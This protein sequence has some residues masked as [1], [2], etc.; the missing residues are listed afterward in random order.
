MELC[1]FLTY[2]VNGCVQVCAYHKRMNHCSIPVT[3]LKYT[4]SKRIRN[5]LS[6]NKCSALAIEFSKLNGRR[7]CGG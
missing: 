4:K 2:E 7:I 6:N 1:V 3:Q 5:P